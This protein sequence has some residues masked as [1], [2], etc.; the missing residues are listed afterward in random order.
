MTGHESVLE[1]LRQDSVDSGA[2]LNVKEEA[3]AVAERRTA[4]ALS[5]TTL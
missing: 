1:T 4:K 2:A 5:I 3:A